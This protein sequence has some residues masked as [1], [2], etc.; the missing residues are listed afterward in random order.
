ML[1]EDGVRL[2]RD[3]MDMPSLFLLGS[4]EGVQW[5]SSLEEAREANG[6][7]VGL[8]RSN[9]S[10]DYFI[11]VVCRGPCTGALGAALDYLRS[12]GRAWVST[13]NF[14]VIQELVK[15]GARVE[16]L[17]A[18]HVM[19]VDRASFRRFEGVPDFIRFSALDEHH[20]EDLRDLLSRWDESRAQWADDMIMRGTA[21]GAWDGERLVGVAATYAM[22]EGWWYLGSL[23]VDPEYRSRKVGISLSSVATEEALARVERAYITVEVDNITSLAINS[24]LNYRSRGVSYLALVSLAQSP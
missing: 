5:L 15:G 18:F 4:L 23:F 24:L 3:T 11:D 17:T 14:G 22:T 6:D 8:Q 16:G 1:S 9:Y 19:E 13:S 20:I 21:F 7:V 12:Y 10:E 2:L